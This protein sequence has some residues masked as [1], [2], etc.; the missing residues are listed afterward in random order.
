MIY[1]ILV[2]SEKDFVKINFFSKAKKM[3]TFSNTK[4]NGYSKKLS[5]PIQAISLE[6]LRSD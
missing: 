2:T 1:N 5:N 3:H 4:I 6:E